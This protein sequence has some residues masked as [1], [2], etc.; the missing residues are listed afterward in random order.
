[1]EQQERIRELDG[2]GCQ[3]VLVAA[4]T[5][6]VLEWLGEGLRCKALQFL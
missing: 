6:E 2:I 3:S 1:M 4:T 5:E